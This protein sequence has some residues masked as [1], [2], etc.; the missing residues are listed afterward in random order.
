MDDFQ[1]FDN[2]SDLLTTA[3]TP[4][5]ILESATSSFDVK[6]SPI[7]CKEK[8]VRIFLSFLIG[9]FSQLMFDR[10]SERFRLF[11]SIG[12]QK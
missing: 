5:A 8:L 10:G 6:E 1:N 7:T 9:V 4:S 11:F 12:A 2:Y 3:S